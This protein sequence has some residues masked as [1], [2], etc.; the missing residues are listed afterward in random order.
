MARTKKPRK[1]KTES[2]SNKKTK[3]KTLPTPK[4]TKSVVK[5][6]SNSEDNI[7]QAS[8]NDKVDEINVR[9]E[10]LQNPVDKT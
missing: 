5:K 10:E 2:K 9:D 1:G 4:R 7:N 3:K 6:V 8:K